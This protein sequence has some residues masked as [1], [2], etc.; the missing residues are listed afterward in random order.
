MLLRQHFGRREQRG[1]PTGID[2][3][4][5]R[6]QRNDCLARTHFALQQ[7]MHRMVG[8]DLGSDQLADTALPVREFERQS[9]VE[10]RKEPAIDRAPRGRRQP[11]R[12]GPSLGEDGLQ[13]ERFV[14]RE[15]STSLVSFGERLRS[16]DSLERLS[17]A[18]QP[19]VVANLLWHWV[20]EEVKRVEHDPHTATN[21]DRACVL[22]GWVHR[23]DLARE[24]R[25][26]D[27]VVVIND[28]DFGIH[29]LQLAVEQID[30]P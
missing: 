20:F 4:Q 13:D 11:R 2:D 26:T 18:D 22:D 6:A 5:H 8:G 9:R 17:I 1:L 10:R 16:V 3:R 28:V 27:N 25:P 29:E 12:G 19:E 21:P 15:S 24:I 30:F 23:Q 7:P 14:P